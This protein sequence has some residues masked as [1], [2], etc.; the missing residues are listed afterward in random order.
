MR[1]LGVFQSALTANPVHGSIR[2]RCH[3]L[4]EMDFRAVDDRLHRSLFV[5]MTRAQWRLE[6]VMS[7]QAERALAQI[8][9]A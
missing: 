1:D 6:C 8:L 5:G 4:A 3:H 9:E 2:R 7:P